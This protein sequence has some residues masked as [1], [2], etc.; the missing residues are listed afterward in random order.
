MHKQYIYVFW[1]F[2]KPNPA[3]HTYTITTIQQPPIPPHP[4]EPTA[5]QIRSRFYLMAQRVLTEL[6]GCCGVCYVVRRIKVQAHGLNAC[7]GARTMQVAVSLRWAELSP[8]LG[9]CRVSCFKCVGPH[10]LADCL[11]KGANRTKGVRSNCWLAEQGEGRFHEKGKWGGEHCS[12][13]YPGRAFVQEVVFALYHARPDYVLRTLAGLGW[14]EGLEMDPNHGCAAIEAPL[15]RTPVEMPEVED[16]AFWVRQPW[17][18]R[19]RVGKGFV[20]LLHFMYLSKQDTVK[21]LAAD[22]YNF[23][24]NL[25]QVQIMETRG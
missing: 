7:P 2:F 15:V 14:W 3:A 11:I 13:P 5:E 24:Q 6:D 20:L 17:L 12:G 10:T 8:A 25:V 9:E 18:N 1:F 16:F 23:W 21:E 22:D 4:R 19:V